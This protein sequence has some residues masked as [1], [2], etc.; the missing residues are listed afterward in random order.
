M[1]VALW[2]LSFLAIPAGAGETSPPSPTVT[3]RSE[4]SPAGTD[5][6]LPLEPI[7]T[8]SP[9]STLEG[10]L[11]FSDDSYRTGIA[12]IQSYQASATRYLSEADIISIREG[13]RLL[14]STA[15]AFDL[16]TLPPAMVDE[17]S[18][19]F[20]ILLKEVLD[21]IDLPP[22]ESIPDAAAMASREPK[23]WTIPDTEIQIARVD[24]G[25]R[26]GEYLFTAE[27]GMRLPE[28]YD[29]VR[30]LPYKPGAAV[31]WSDFVF[32]QP[33]G[34]ALALQRIVPPGLLFNMPSWT[35]ITFLDQPLWR[36]FSMGVVL[37]VAFVVVRVFSRL[38]RYGV[39]WHWPVLLRPLSFVIVVPLA[40]RIVTLVLR[41]SG[42]VYEW[43]TLS[44][45]AAFYL[46]IT[47][48][49]WVAGGV[50]IEYLISAEN[51]RLPS[52]I[53][54][55]LIRIVLRL[56]TII[57]AAG[58][59]IYGADSLGL[60]A[61]SILAGL[62]VGGL[63]VALAAQQ[64]VANLLASLIIMFERPFTVGDWVKLPGV[65]GI[66]EAVGFRSTRIR[67]FHDSLVTI[68]SGEL[69][70]STIDNMQL[71]AYR[72]VDS[73][74]NITYDTPL[75]K[76]ES[77]VAGIKQILISH[78]ATRKDNIRVVFFDLG[79]SSLDIQLRF[80]LKAPDRAT[81]FEERQRI[82]LDILRLAEAQGVQFAFPT[83]T[84]HIESGGPERTM[85]KS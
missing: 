66:V 50:L 15:R 64:T 26:T 76:I 23:S 85:T 22:M 31:G 14:K 7:N 44:L 74:L 2:V 1:A 78:P 57:V 20:V 45:L 12:I 84:L 56:A 9:R 49:V 42:Y 8:S 79:P 80:F 37:G 73:V 25:P 32:Y 11:K 55:Q 67:T 6:T 28:F 70:N 75:E 47:W 41:I 69:I 24:K 71:R 83:Q 81:E 39:S 60:P 51:K 18:R 59:L 21:H 52:S 65:E 16:S 34:V 53:D 3:L 35:R 77:F 10:T 68:P 29:R 5:K 62:G 19:R 48:T 46:A 30:H 4:S 82:L 58:I 17:S 27:T 54:S 38:S 33:A 63:A 72:L 13:M 43:V 40:G 61:Y 36:W